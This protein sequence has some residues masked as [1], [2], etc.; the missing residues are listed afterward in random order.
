M[1]TCMHSP[2]AGRHAG[3]PARAICDSFTLAVALANAIELRSIANLS[4][5]GPTFLAAP[6]R[7]VEHGLARNIIFV[8]APPTEGVTT[9]FPSEIPGVV[10]VDAVGHKHSA[11]DVLLVLVDRFCMLTPEAGYRLR[12][13]APPW[14]RRCFRGHRFAV[15]IG[16]ADEIRVLVVLS[17]GDSIILLR[18]ALSGSAGRRST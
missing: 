18:V 16:E 17:S 7:L 11:R 9:G 2:P 5:G 12:V 1:R 14:P 4:L 6:R 10:V 3:E 15:V 13:P 8:V